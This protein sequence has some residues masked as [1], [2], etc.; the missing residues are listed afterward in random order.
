[1][2]RFWND[3]DTCT[4]AERP[5]ET[6]IVTEFAEPSREVNE[7]TIEQSTIDARITTTTTTYFKDSADKDHEKDVES[8]KIDT[9]V[10]Y[11][12]PSV[13][14]EQGAIKSTL[15]EAMKGLSNERKDEMKRQEEASIS[16]ISRKIPQSVVPLKSQYLIWPWTSSSVGTEG[17]FLRLLFNMYFSFNVFLSLLLSLNMARLIEL[18]CQPVQ[19]PMNCHFLDFVRYE[20]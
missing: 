6:T 14:Y 19:F 16:E 4:F 3:F 17:E 20:E 2:D 7:V 5:A 18:I 10:S 9:A 1:M 12:K 8:V 13:Q 15:D 11:V